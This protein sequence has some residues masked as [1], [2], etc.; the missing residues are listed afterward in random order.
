MTETGHVICVFP[1]VDEAR[2]S[3]LDD[4]SLNDLLAAYYRE[5]DDR[6]VNVDTTPSRQ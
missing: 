4:Y 5:F 1:S 3:C 2:L 6:E